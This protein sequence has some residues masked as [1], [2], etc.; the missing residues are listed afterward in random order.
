VNIIEKK[1]EYGEKLEIQTKNKGCALGYD[2]Q[3]DDF[4]IGE[5]RERRVGICRA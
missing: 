5:N 1:W 2:K 3:G 4:Y